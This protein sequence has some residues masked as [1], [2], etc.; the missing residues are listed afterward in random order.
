MQI[1]IYVLNYKKHAILLDC[2]QI[3][4]AKLFCGLSEYPNI[5]VY[6]IS[7]NNVLITDNVTIWEIY[8]PNIIATELHT[9]LIQVIKKIKAITSQQRQMY[10]INNKVYFV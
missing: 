10:T 8:T 7:P 5:K 1:K 9:Q 2:L 4:L 6:W 3:K